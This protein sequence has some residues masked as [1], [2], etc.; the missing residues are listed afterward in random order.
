MSSQDP[1][2][3]V[4][5]HLSDPGELGTHLDAFRCD[6]C[7]GGGSGAERGA[8]VTPTDPTDHGSDFRCDQCGKAFPRAALA[9]LEEELLG[10]VEDAEKGD[11]AELEGLLGECLERVG[12]TSHV[13]MAIKRH[14]GCHSVLS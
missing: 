1:L 7:P 14:L 2:L 13:V 5:F 12:P 11:D 10:R 9:R 4:I 3:R 8:T 6:S